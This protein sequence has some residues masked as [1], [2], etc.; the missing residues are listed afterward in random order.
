MNK[1]T[2]KQKPRIREKFERKHLKEEINGR[3]F[4]IEDVV[5]NIR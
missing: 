5:A 4:L 2:S 1:R 3:D